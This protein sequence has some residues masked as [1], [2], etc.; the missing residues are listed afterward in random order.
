MNDVQVLLK[1]RELVRTNQVLV[2]IIDRER[3][4]VKS[5]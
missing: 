4:H 1:T 5:S 3:N 2:M